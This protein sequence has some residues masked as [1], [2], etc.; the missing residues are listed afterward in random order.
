[1]YERGW[2]IKI[3]LQIILRQNYLRFLHFINWLHLSKTFYL[4]LQS[5][6]RGSEPARVP[7][8]PV[9]GGRRRRRQ[10]DACRPRQREA[11]EEEDQPRC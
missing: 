3:K 11:A 1:M 4:K 8:L 9:Q 7:L 6:D 2:E 5:S 10:E